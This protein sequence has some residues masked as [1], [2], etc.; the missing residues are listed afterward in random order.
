MM[1]EKRYGLEEILKVAMSPVVPL[2]PRYRGDVTSAKG[3][4]RGHQGDETYGDDNEG[5]LAPRK[6]HRN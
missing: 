4:C 3:C 1:P 5:D 2:Y 6:R